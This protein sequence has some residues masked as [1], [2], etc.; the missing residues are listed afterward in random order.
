MSG[1]TI[2]SCACTCI[3]I[4]RPYKRMKSFLS[5]PL[6]SYMYQIRCFILFYSGRRQPILIQLT[7]TFFFLHLRLCL[8]EATLPALIACYGLSKVF[9]SEVRPISVAEI[10]FRIGYLPQQ[11]VADA[12]FASCTY[13]EFWVRHEISVQMTTEVSSVSCFSSS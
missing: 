3:P 2:L 5:Y 8:A 6:M 11:I 7:P 1:F 9:L 12:Q 4:A 13:E 10:Q